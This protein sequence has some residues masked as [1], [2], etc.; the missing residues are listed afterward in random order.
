VHRALA[1][2]LYLAVFCVF[3]GVLYAAAPTDE[4]PELRTITFFENCEVL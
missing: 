1:V 2:T 3:F 4:R